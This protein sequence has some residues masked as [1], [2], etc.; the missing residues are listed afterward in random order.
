MVEKEQASLVFIEFPPISEEMFP[1]DLLPDLDLVLLT[2][3]SN[4]AWTKADQ[5][6]FETIS[7]QISGDQEVLLTGVLPEH[8]EIFG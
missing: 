1:M 6:S 8:S 3:R 4:R 5:K 7:G 2:I